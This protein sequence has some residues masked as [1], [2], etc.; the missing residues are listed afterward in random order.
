MGSRNEIETYF[1]QPQAGTV[2]LY[3]AEEFVRARLTLRTAGPVAI[4]TRE[5]LA[6]VLSGRGIQLVPDDEYE[7]VIPAGQRLYIIS[8]AVNRVNFTIEPIPWLEQIMRGMGGGFQRLSD[9]LSLIAG[10][11]PEPLSQAAS[12][13][14]RA[15]PVSLPRTR[16]YE[17]LLERFKR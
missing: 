11:K 9:L 12:A 14:G 3:S 1:T 2:L 7:V 15:T 6:P 10:R 17:S 13:G 5:E 16:P 8:E 4:G